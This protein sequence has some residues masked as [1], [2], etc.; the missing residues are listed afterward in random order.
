MKLVQVMLPGETRQGDKETR[1]Q[2]DRT[3]GTFEDTPEEPD[4]ADLLLR[5]GFQEFPCILRMSF[6]RRDW[7]TG[8]LEEREL[9]SSCLPVSQSPSLPVCLYSPLPTPHSPLLQTLA[10]TFVDT[11]DYPELNSRRTPEEVLAGYRAYARDPSCWWL[12][13]RQQNIVGVL[14]IAEVQAAWEIAYLGVVP[15]VR[16]QG[17]GRTI[18]RFAL[19]RAA[20]A[21]IQIV[22]LLV[23]SRNTPAIRLYESQGFKTEKSQR[24]FLL[25]GS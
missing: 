4:Q 13:E 12:A 20:S 8:S 16:G 1:R 18:L 11:R 7:E 14:I 9:A 24:V 10:R 6:D 3:F 25:F 22:R 15:E 5:H 21:G 19:D 2:G 23:D 17:V